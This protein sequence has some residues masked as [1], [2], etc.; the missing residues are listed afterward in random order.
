MSEGEV[1]IIGDAAD[2]Y[3]AKD[4]IKAIGR[5]F[6]EREALKIFSEGYQFFLINL[7]EYF[8]NEKAIARVKG[9]VIGEK[10]KMKT[11]IESATESYISVYG[12]TI[13][14]ISKIDSIE[15]AKEAIEMLLRGVQHSS[16]YNY[17][18]KIR[19]QLLGER[20]TGK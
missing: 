5:G 11:E 13:G 19:R 4:V 6:E 16:V 9:R 12:N 3:F 14:V 15:Y 20:L 10:G 8:P 17:L 1:E 7:K 2:V 18:A